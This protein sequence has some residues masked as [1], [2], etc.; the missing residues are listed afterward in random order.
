MISPWAYADRLPGIEAESG[1]DGEPDHTTENQTIQGDQPWPKQLR[2]NALTRDALA[3]FQPERNTA[4]RP[5]QTRPRADSAM[6]V[7]AARIRNA[8]ARW[9]PKLA[10]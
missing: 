2:I 10:F 1:S 4:A 9:P 8:P 3:P 7:V 6:I 5:A